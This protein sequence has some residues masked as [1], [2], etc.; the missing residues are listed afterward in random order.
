MLR[1]GIAV[2]AML[3]AAPAL[4]QN[5][6]DAKR[7]CSGHDGLDKVIS[8]CTAAI[9][10]S[11]DLPEGMVLA[12]S[13]RGIVYASEGQ[14]AKAIVDLNEAIRLNPRR[15]DTFINRGITYDLM[16]DDDRAIADYSEAIRLMPNSS[17]ALSRRGAVF[18]RKGDLTR[19]KQDSEASLR[20]DS[21]N[22]IAAETL[23]ALR[24]PRQPTAGPQ[25]TA[26]GP[27]GTRTLT[28]D[29]ASS[30]TYA[31]AQWVPESWSTASPT[32]SLARYGSGGGSPPRTQRRPPPHRQANANCSA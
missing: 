22:K 2:L 8:G 18:L 14:F 20:L 26:G 4:A 17:E 19:A 32:N 10:H 31:G 24:S 1:I 15:H 29:G 5:F 6:E 9:Q 21:G 12:L 3:M 25:V 11:R 27:L 16:Q 30:T 13:N 28:L 23:T 7:Q